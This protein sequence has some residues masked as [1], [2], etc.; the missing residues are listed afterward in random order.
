MV[1]YPP[2]PPIDEL[3]SAQEASRCLGIA[4]STFYAWLD[5]S[6]RGALLI[7]GEPVTINYLQGGPKGQGRIKLERREIER[8]KD[9]MRVAPRAVRVRRPPVAPRH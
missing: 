4:T 3:L 6:D 8:L 9:R 2:A 1:S 5:Q 7:R